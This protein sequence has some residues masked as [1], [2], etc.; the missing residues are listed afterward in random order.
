MHSRKSV[1]VFPDSSALS[2]L[3]PFSTTAP[4]DPSPPAEGQLGVT[5]S[6][7]VRRV[8][9]VMVPE[10]LA[11][12]KRTDAAHWYPGL[13]SSLTASEEMLCCLFR[14]TLLM[15]HDRIGLVAKP[16]RIG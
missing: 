6:T 9:S 13:S 10:L 15:N 8:S 1:V 7:S 14:N 3:T 12:G 2:S 16:K 4:S 11:K 5:L